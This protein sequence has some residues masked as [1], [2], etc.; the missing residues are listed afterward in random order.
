LCVAGNGL[1]TTPKVPW[2]PGRCRGAATLSQQE[3]NSTADVQ[4]KRVNFTRLQRRIIQVRL[5][6]CPRRRSLFLQVIDRG[7]HAI[8]VAPRRCRSKRR[9]NLLICSGKEQILPVCSAELSG[10]VIMTA[11]NCSPTVSNRRA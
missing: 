2:C 9:T 5:G 6:R 8:A 1:G 11:A 4:R 10:R 7:T 3:K